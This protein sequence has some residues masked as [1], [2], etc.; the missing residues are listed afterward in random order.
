MFHKE[1]GFTL[2][3]VMVVLTIIGTAITMAVPSWENAI[4]KHRLT[5]ATEQVAALL[6][7]AQGEAQKRNQAVSLVFNRTGDESWCFGSS[8]G[9]GGCD[10]TETDSEAAQYCAVDG[11][12]QRIVSTNFQSALLTQVS[13][14][15][16]G[17]GDSIITFDPVRGILQP[18]GDRL[19]LT[20]RSASDDFQ[21]RV[22]IGP[23]G[24]LTLCNP[25][26]SRK[27]A[28][29]KSCAV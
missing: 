20:L 22:I 25:D 6:L 4:Q 17:T 5:S 28:G 13:D 18:A 12:E 3:E 9:A 29:Y 1:S 27:V 11:I 14:T 21:L 15:R 19:Q 24:L 26:S 8:V 2:I 10:C 7:V 23:T 16:P